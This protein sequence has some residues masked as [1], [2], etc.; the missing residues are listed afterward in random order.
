MISYTSI[1]RRLVETRKVGVVSELPQMESPPKEHRVLH[2]FCDRHSFS[3]RRRYSVVY[4]EHLC[5]LAVNQAHKEEQRNHLLQG[6][7][8]VT[9]TNVDFAFFCIFS[10]DLIALPHQNPG[11]NRLVQPPLP[12]L[13][14]F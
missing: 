3:P 2:A 10:S 6:S 7:K 12:S 1:L 14:S 9:I 8:Q 13:F 4:L 11:T 5:V